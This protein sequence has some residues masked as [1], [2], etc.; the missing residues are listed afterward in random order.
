MVFKMVI[1]NKTKRIA[2]VLGKG[3]FFL[4]E[5]NSEVI[6]NWDR[7]WI[8]NGTLER[9]FFFDANYLDRTIVYI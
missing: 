9:S 8:L 6:W 2:G 1:F 4:K 7:S 3:S 5:D